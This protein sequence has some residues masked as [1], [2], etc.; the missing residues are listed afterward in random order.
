M[1]AAE[2]QWSVDTP[3]KGLY[4]NHQFDAFVFLHDKF[5]GGCLGG[6]AGVVRVRYGVAY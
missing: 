6:G 1:R 2:K 4:I 3:E 5:A